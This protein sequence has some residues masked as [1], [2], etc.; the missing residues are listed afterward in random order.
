MLW[1]RL[2]NLSKS[3]DGTKVLDSVSLRVEQGTVLSISGRNGSGKTTL[4]RIIAGLLRPSGGS[5]E[6]GEG[7]EPP[8]QPARLRRELG[9]VSPDLALYESLSARENL[10]FFARVRGCT[11]DP[12]ELLDYVGLGGRGDEPIGSFSSGMRQRLKLAFALQ[13][14][15]RVL[16]LDEPGVTLDE[17]G[18]EVVVRA[19][20]EQRPRGVVLLASNDPEEVALGDDVLRLDV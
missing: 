4:L 16:L 7:D 15:P 10:D 17:A 2:A 20:A 11:R 8:W 14:S 13:A 18:R 19:V 12:N 5:V 3:F 6:C 9:Y 1:L